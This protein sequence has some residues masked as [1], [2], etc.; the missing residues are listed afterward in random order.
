MFNTHLQAAANYALQ[1]MFRITV[2]S[3]DSINPSA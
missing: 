2:K 1:Q 3:Q